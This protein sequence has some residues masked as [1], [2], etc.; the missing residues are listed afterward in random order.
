MRKWQWAF[1][2]AAAVWTL[3]LPVAAFEASRTAAAPLGYG[4]AFVIYAIGSLVCHQRPERSFYL[5]GAQLPVCA[6][7]VGLYLGATLAAAATLL[8]PEVGRRRRRAGWNALRI[9]SRLKLLF[10]AA[11]PTLLTL[12]YEWT[13]GRAPT[14]SV[15]GVTAAALGSGLAVLLLSGLEQPE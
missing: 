11:L 14:N 2:S 8:A 5:W 1:V 7:C 6:R 13:T 9:S 4:F 12:V 10:C 3:S 15:R